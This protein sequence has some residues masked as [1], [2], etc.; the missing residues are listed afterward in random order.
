MKLSRRRIMIAAAAL[1]AGLSLPGLAAGPVPLRRWRGVVM[2]AE[3]EI[4]LGV[5]DPDR[6]ND[7]VGKCLAEAARLEQIYS[8]YQPRSELVRLNKAGALV[9]PSPELLEVLSASRSL[10]RASGGAFDPTV[11]PLWRLYADWYSTLDADPAGPPP[12]ARERALA[13]VGFD[14]VEF[15]PDAVRL[16]RPGAMLTLNGIAQGH[17]TDKVAELLRREGLHHVLVAFGEIRALGTRPDG[18]PWR[19]GLAAPG[20]SEAGPLL[21]VSERAVATSAGAAGPFG[22]SGSHNHILDPRDG[23]SPRHHTA[24]T[25][26][27]PTA[28]LADG[29][30]TAIALMPTAEA[31]RLISQHEEVEAHLTDHQ[32]RVTR[33]A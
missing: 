23:S 16:H 5:D 2:G 8:L 18:S 17:M 27:A 3:A 29:I 19:V 22:G 14:A 28:V 33:I 24:V 13:R 21:S 7:L 12:E 1:P 26:T 6:A 4:V 10:W 20:Q 9:S 11:Q 15:G 25:V 32:G 31:R 30:S